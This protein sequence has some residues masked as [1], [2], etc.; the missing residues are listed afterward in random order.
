MRK[1]DARP[2]THIY[3]DTTGRYLGQVTRVNGNIIHLEGT[4]QKIASIW[5][6]KKG[7]QPARER[8]NNPPPPPNPPPKGRL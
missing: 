8:P 6:T 3:H 2:G 1:R 7:P 5:E 4:D